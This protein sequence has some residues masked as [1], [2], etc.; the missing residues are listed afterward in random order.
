MSIRISHAVVLVRLADVFDP[1]I[2]SMT[3]SE[4]T[5]I[6]FG[7]AIAHLNTLY[8]AEN[9]D[10]YENFKYLFGNSFA[11]ESEHQ[12]LQ[13]AAADLAADQRF[14]LA[15]ICRDQI[16]YFDNG[17]ETLRFCPPS[18]VYVTSA[19][20]SFRNSW[21]RINIQTAQQLKD[22]ITH[23]ASAWRYTF[24]NNPDF[25]DTHVNIGDLPLGNQTARLFL[26][27]TTGVEFCS[28]S[29]RGFN[30]TDL[31]EWLDDEECDEEYVVTLSPDRPTVFFHLRH[32]YNPAKRHSLYRMFQYSTNVLSIL[33]YPKTEPKER[34]P[35]LVGVELELNT[36]YDVK[37]LIDACAE[38]FFIAKPDSTISGCKRNC[39]ELVTVP[40]SFKYLK[41]AYAQWFDKLD[42]EQFD[43]SVSTNNGMHVHIGRE[44]FEDQHHMRNFCWFFNNPANLDFIYKM[45]ERGNMTSF[46]QWSP[47][48]RFGGL[49][50]ASAFRKVYDLLSSGGLR[51]ATNFK[52]GRSGATVEVR[53]FR[54]IVSYASICK[55][56][57]FVEAVFHFTKSL[58]SY[59]QLSLSAFVDWL[60]AQPRNKYI[61]LRKFLDAL[62][63]D[64]ILLKADLDDWLFLETN[65]DRMLARLRKAPFPLTK[66]HLAVLNKGRK[67]P[68][69]FDSD[70][71]LILKRL[72]QG[73][74][75]AYDKSFAQRYLRPAAPASA[76]A[77]A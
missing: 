13:T 1:R 15:F 73:K 42:Y 22:H 16:G 77:A 21:D 7:A 60:K 28:N 50:R 27:Y 3:T 26:L 19:R 9:L 36:D 38:P 23:F 44:H 17:S 43:T 20:V 33:P 10:N 72:D 74:L 2:N 57:E 37:P 62:P 35:V 34:D 63:M 39:M 30:A 32:V 68:F 64:K 69:L 11:T 25:L 75:A 76:P 8:S 41:R 45:S 40:S 70:G 5:R 29:H 49:S 24:S 12:F 58:S 55:N 31:A 6:T 54:G 46:Q 47:T 71:Q 51:G 56:L 66:A 14:L 18:G 4:T 52:G 65:P 48:L 67:N 53:I 59:R 61:M